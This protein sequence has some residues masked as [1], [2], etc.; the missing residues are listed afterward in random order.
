MTSTSQN[1]ERRRRTLET[2]WVVGVGSYFSVNF[3]ETL[4]EDSS[5]FTFI[6]R[7]LE[8]IPEEKNQWK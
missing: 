6:Q 7:I 4:C 5:D 3:D 1:G 2:S 8:T